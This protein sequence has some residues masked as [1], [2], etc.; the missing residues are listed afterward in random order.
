MHPI[1]SGIFE[2]SILMRRSNW[3][4]GAQPAD[5]CGKL[6]SFP[7]AAEERPVKRYRLEAQHRAMTY[8]VNLISSDIPSFLVWQSP[9]TVYSLLACLGTN[10]SLSE[11]GS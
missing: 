6:H 10:H 9:V 3:D 8:H 1:H 4:F 5:F 11:A 2:R 7:G